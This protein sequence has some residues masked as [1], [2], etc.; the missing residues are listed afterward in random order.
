MNQKWP[1]NSKVQDEAHGKYVGLNSHE[2]EHEDEDLHFE[3][4]HAAGHQ[5]T[6]GV[7]LISYA[8]MMTLLMGFFALMLSM[9]LSRKQGSH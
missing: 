1:K 3:E 2:E 7:W 9:S 5:D 4:E 6:E 8:D